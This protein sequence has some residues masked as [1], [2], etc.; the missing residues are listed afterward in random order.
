M[1]IK[2]VPTDSLIPYANNAKI[3][4]HDQ[5]LLLASSIKEF[6]FNN[7]ILTDGDKG[8]IAG[9]GRLLAAQRLELKEVPTIEL[10]HLTP[11]QKR[12]YVLADNRIGEIVEGNKYIAASA[13]AE[14]ERIQ[15]G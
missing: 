12:A 5:V 13:I 7:P 11:H 6:G 15:Y 3:H 4:D 9:H 8:V 14:N 10:S 1:Q 2:L